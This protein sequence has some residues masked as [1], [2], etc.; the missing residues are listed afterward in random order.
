MTVL[1]NTTSEN[2][3]QLWSNV[4]SSWF[5]VYKVEGAGAERQQGVTGLG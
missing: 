1:L 4:K 3:R 2:E 5:Q